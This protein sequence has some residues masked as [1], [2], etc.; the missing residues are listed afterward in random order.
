MALNTFKSN[1]LRP[2]RF[3]GLTVKTEAERVLSDGRQFNRREKHSSWSLSVSLLGDRQWLHRGHS[4]AS[5]LSQ[6]VFEKTCAITQKNVK[7]H[8]LL[9]FQKNRKNVRI[10]FHGCLMFIV[11]LHCCQ[12]L[13]SFTL[14]VQQWLRMD[15]TRG[16]GNWITTITENSFRWIE[17]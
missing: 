9:D 17:D 5:P 12:N 1:H 3:K 4:D 2:L 8:V 15:H 16:S 6:S 10:I 13:T 14:D 7:S 11:P